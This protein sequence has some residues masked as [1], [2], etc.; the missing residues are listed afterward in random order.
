MKFGFLAGGGEFVPSVFKEFSKEEIRLF[1]L[2]FYNAF[3]KDDLEIPLKY[4]KLANSLE[5]IFLLYIA[6]FLP[7]N[8]TCKISNKIYEEHAS[9]N[10]SFLLDTPK[11]SVAKIIKMI[12]YKNL[13]GLVFEADFMFKN[14]VFNKIYKTHLGKNIF[15]K[16]EILYLKKPNNVYLCVMPCFNKFDLKE[17]D[18][19]EKINFAFSLS[20][21]LHEI[22]IVLPRQK[23]FCR[24]LQIQGPIVDGK[25]S[26]KLVPYS[27]TNKIIQRS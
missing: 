8:P 10:Y 12:Y 3:V 23:G 21:Q 7:K 24:H 27:I 20:N 2:V 4:A 6:E 15:I 9:K 17:K 22:Y 16:D 26:I 13:K 25:K 19:Q 11:D 1:F 14:Y 18:L 5:E